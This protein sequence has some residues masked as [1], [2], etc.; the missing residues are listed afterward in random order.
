MVAVN[1]GIQ[2]TAA[3]ALDVLP[4]AL[5]VALSGRAPVRIDGQTLAPEQQLMLRVL[6]LR[7]EPP[8]ES[9]TPQQAREA[10]R[11]LAATLGGPPEPVRAVEELE[12]DLPV[13][14]AARHYA[15]VP[16]PGAADADPLIVYLHGGGFVYG[17]LDTHD[18]LCR[19]LCRHA[20]VHVLAVDY[21]LAPE[22]PF[23]AAAEDA[24]AAFAWAAAHAEELGAD[25]ERIGVAG[26][27]AG[28][29]LAAVVAQQARR[30]GVREPALQVLIYP[31]VDFSGR[32]R[33]RELFGE[34]FLLTNADMDWFERNYLGALDGPQAHD[35]RASPLLAE[36]LSGLAPALVVTAGFDPLRDE[37]EAYARALRQ[38]GNVVLER[39]FPGYVHAFVSCAGVSRG[40]RE[41]VL[42]IAG[43][44]RGLLASARVPLARS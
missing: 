34:G 36:E 27:S 15:P 40:A 35:P 39:R 23:P 28:G 7:R 31:V 44:T 29:N 21:R 41:A 19:L 1:Q 32:S 14:L 17:D 13:A 9:V 24:C 12:L 18:G 2:R 20:Q 6:A 11:R 37:G 38:A 43:M 26:D 30:R 22:H 33:S 8:I 16:E 10:R 42:E 4:A 25:P 5:Q 3:R